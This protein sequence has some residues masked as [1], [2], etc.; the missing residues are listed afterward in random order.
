MIKFVVAALWI[1]AATLGSVYYSFNAVRSHP[2]EKA[3]EASL[4]GGLDYV[5]M[6]VVTV[7][8][9][10]KGAVHGYFLAKLVYTVE[11]EKKAKLVLPA[12]TL[13]AD[14]VYTYLYGNPLIDFTRKEKFDIDAF[15]AGLRDAVNA[16]VG[17][18]MVH[19]VL[20][21]QVD[22]LTKDDI[23]DNS[24]RKRKVA[25]AMEPRPAAPA[26]GGGH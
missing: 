7:P 15:R 8:V 21:E 17:T 26:K 14:E 6:G 9:M 3:P 20:V 2:D 13:L 22:Y 18:D 25:E 23:R 4:L 16:R 19:E 24:A 5:S 1:A 10:V 11:P 12:E